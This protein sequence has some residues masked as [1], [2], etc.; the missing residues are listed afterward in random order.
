[1]LSVGI[2]LNCNVIV[3]VLS[4]FIAGLN[5]ATDAKV[6]D[7][8]NM[9]V[10]VAIQD[11]CCFVCGAIIDDDVIISCLLNYLNCLLD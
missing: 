3:V 9:I 8:I 10:I 2:K 11:L 1:M 7:K 5:S 6:G 4:V